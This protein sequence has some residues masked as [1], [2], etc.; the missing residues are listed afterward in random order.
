MSLEQTMQRSSALVADLE[1]VC[2]DLVE[3]DPA[4]SEA[5]A[6]ELLAVLERS[7]SALSAVQAKHTAVL[8]QYRLNKQAA[9]GVPKDRWGTGLASEVGLARGDSPARGKRHLDTAHALVGCLPHTLHALE[10]GVIHEEHA[11]VVATETKWLSTK[12][13]R[14]VDERIAHRLDGVGPRTLGNMVRGE[15]QKLDQVTARD[16]QERSRSQRRVSVRPAPGGM[17]YISALVPM[18]QAVGVLAC[19]HK[20]A[21]SRVADGDTVDPANPSGPR[22]SRDQLMADLLIERATGQTTAPA[23]AAEVQL[24]MTDAAL[25]GDGQA[26]AWLTG[27]G[28]IPAETARNWVA[29]PNAEIFLRRVFTRPENHQ[30][31]GMESRRRAFPDGLKRMVTLRDGVCRTPYCDAPIQQIDHITPVNNGGPTS[32]DNASGLCAACNQTKEATG[33]RHDGNPDHLTVITPTG[34][35]YTTTTP[36]VSTA[37]PPDTGDPPEEHGPD[38]TGPPDDPDD[39]PPEIDPN[40]RFDT[41]NYRHHRTEITMRIAA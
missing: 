6:I 34:H 23:V 3:M 30:L 15:A 37:E 1:A 39:G 26:P 32:W 40:P 4:G 36:P 19:L 18:P 8:E 5:E 29:D 33:W 31:V 13:R 7:K 16:R 14:M 22:R 9:A 27:H 12:H 35:Q 25:F 2:E 21:T 20:A 10:A 17:A 38:D 41:N 24:V 28:P 11:Q